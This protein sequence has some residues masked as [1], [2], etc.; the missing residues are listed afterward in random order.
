VYIRSWVV[1]A[2]Y[3]LTHQPLFLQDAQNVL[4]Q[5]KQDFPNLCDLYSMIMHPTYEALAATLGFQ[6]MR[7][8]PS[9]IYWMYLA[10]DRFLALD[11]ASAFPS[12]PAH[13][14]LKS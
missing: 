10:V 11:I 5:M 3:V 12:F 13:K 6:K 4:E 1:E 7:N 14:T 9:S 2:P 8:S